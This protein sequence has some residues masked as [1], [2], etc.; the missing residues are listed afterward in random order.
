[1]LKVNSGARQRNDVCTLIISLL[2]VTVPL[3]V[4][5]M[6]FVGCMYSSIR[7]RVNV[8]IINT[9]VTLNK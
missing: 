1:M 6:V 9:E 4:F 2:D 3:S 8:S 7:Y 5:L